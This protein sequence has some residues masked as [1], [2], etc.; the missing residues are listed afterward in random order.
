ML[1]VIQIMVEIKIKGGNEA[2]VHVSYGHIKNNNFIETDGG[3][4]A[5]G[6][7]GSRIEI[8]ILEN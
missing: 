5:L 3:I 8:Q 7:N 1:L 4:G 2:G 6:V